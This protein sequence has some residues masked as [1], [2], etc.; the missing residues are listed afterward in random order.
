MSEAS[1]TPLCR[2]LLFTLFGFAVFSR[3]SRLDPSAKD[4]PPVLC[5]L[6]LA[7]HQS[8]CFLLHHYGG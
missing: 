5:F 7:I 8:W 6:S 2:Q 4:N 3:L 1:E